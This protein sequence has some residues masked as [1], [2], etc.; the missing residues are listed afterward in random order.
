MP[1]LDTAKVDAFLKEKYGAST[2]KAGIDTAK[3]DAFIK[4]K[5]AAPDKEVVQQLKTSNSLRNMALGMQ[6]DNLHDQIG[7]IV[8]SNP[9]HAY[10][11][12]TTD[13]ASEAMDVEEAVERY[14]YNP[15]KEAETEMP[16]SVVVADNVEMRGDILRNKIKA[17]YGAT[18]ASEGYGVRAGKAATSLVEQLP[19]AEDGRYIIDGYEYTHPEA[20]SVMQ[21]VVENT[22]HPD[23]WKTDASYRDH[24]SWL[25]HGKSY[26][27]ILDEQYAS[28]SSKLDTLQSKIAGRIKKQAAGI[29][30]LSKD[31]SMALLGISEGE[32][33]NKLRKVNDLL[34][35]IKKDNFWSGLDE[36]FDRIDAATLGLSSFLSE[37]QMT[38]V[39]DK[40]YNGEPLTERDQIYYDL[41]EVEQELKDIRS[42]KG[43]SW[44]NT[45]GSSLGTSAEMVPSFFVGMGSVG[46]IFKMSSLPLK[47]GMQLVKNSAKKGAWEGIKK[48]VGATMKV[49]GRSLGNV[50]KAE[51][52]GMIA[53]PFL[54]STWSEVA[55]KRGDQYSL[56][57][58][59][60]VYKPKAMWKDIANAW[61]EQ[62]N[63][64]ASEFI[65]TRIGA[66]LGAGASTFGRMLGLDRVANKIG[67]SSQATKLLGYEKPQW[68]KVLQRNLG[69][70]GPVAEPLSEVWGDVAS[71]LMKEG[72]TGDGEFS[73]FK[74][75]DY[76]TTTLAVSTIYGGSVAM[77]TAPL[78]IYDYKHSPLQGMRKQRDGYLGMIKDKVLR[79]NLLSISSMGDLEQM[80]SALA[81]LDWGDMNK[82]DIA[83]G[84]DFIRADMAYKVMIGDAKESVRQEQYQNVVNDAY[85]VA[86]KGATGNTP[87]GYIVRVEA[88]DGSLYYVLR[89]SLDSASE[90][91]LTCLN[92]EGNVVP[93][94]PSKIK[95][96]STASLEDF[97]ADG[98][99]QLFATQVEMER[100][101]DIIRDYKALENPTAEDIAR[102]M[103]AFGA[104]QQNVGDTVTLVDG[105]TGV[106]QEFDAET[107]KYLVNVVSNDGNAVML[108]V[109]FYDIL[110]NDAQMASAQSSRFA[111]QTLD[112][113]DISLAQE[114]S[115]EEMQEAEA[116]GDLKVGD[117]IT[118][119]NGTQGRVIGFN[120]GNVVVDEN[121]ENT[122]GSMRDAYIEEYSLNDIIKDTPSTEA[123][124]EV[125][126]PQEA[127]E[128]PRPVEDIKIVPM[129][130]DGS[131]DYDAITD[132]S[133]FAE[134]YTKE[135]GSREEATNEVIAMRDALAAQIAENA[136]K[137][138]KATT[139][140]ERV[141]M[142]KAANA[143]A[144][145][146]AFYNK[147][148]EMLAPQEVAET[149]V[150]PIVEDATAVE[151][152][153]PREVGI[154][155]NEY[156]ERLLDAEKKV[157]NA[158]A[159]AL[160]LTVEFVKE[161]V[162]A[163]G[164]RAN[165]KIDGNKVIVGWRE[166][167]R[168]IS[169]LIGH[170]F[171]HRM[172][173]LA[174]ETYEMFKGSVQTYMGE[175]RWNKDLARMQAQ[176]RAQNKTISTELLEEEVIADFTGELVEKKDVFSSYI[177]ANKENKTL[178]DKIAEV[179]R[180]IRDFLR[181]KGVE[182][183][184]LE[185]VVSA[186]N[187]LITEA[188]AK[189]KEGV[190]GSTP[191]KYSMQA[192]SLLGV[193]NISLDKLRKVIKMGGLA[194]PSVAVIDV[195]KQTHDDYGEYSLVLPKNM[196]DARQGKN[197]GT[198]AG[199]AWT[200]T[201]P[202]IIKRIKDEKSYSRFH[203]DI[204]ALP[205]AMRNKVR[206]EF[207]S[208]MEG[209]S[210]DPLAYW[211]LFEKGSTPELVLV[212]S[213][214]SDD[215]TNAVSE[216]TKGS[217]S[218]YGLTPDER[219]KCVD[220]YIA[221]KFNGDRAAFEQEMQERI[222]R[223]T[224][225]LET[226]KSDRVKKWAQD[227]IDAIKEYGF[228]YDAVADFI[229]DVGYD[230]REKGTVND[231]A[232]TMA[233]REQ[234]KANNLEADY[235]AWLNSL[236]ERYGIDEYIFD[237]YTNSGN[238]RYLP[239]TLENV[240]KWM[241]KQ[242][243]QGADATFPSF[244]VFIATAIPKM[245]SLESIRK[246][247]ALLGK[248]KEEYDA[249]REKWE[250][251][252]FEL[253]KRLQPDAKGF[254]DYGYWR[255]IEAVGKS[256]P[257]EFIK[258]EY[259]IEMS[260]E[261][262]AM[263][264][265]MVNAIRTE[266][267]ARYFETKF[268][269]PLQL[270]DFTA[271][272]VPN[273]IPLDVESRLKDAGVEVIEYE[274]GDNASRAEAMQKASQ[275][276]NVRFSLQEVNTRF[277][278]ELATLTEENKDK[279]ILSL[280]TP[281][282]KLLAGGVVNKPMKLYGAKVIKKQKLHGFDLSEIKNLPL[283][284]ANPI[285]VFNNYQSDENR[286]VLT[287]L[288]T[289]D[290]NFLVSL[291]VGKG[292]DIDFNIVATVFGKGDDNIVDWFN[293]GLATY[294]DKEKALDYLHHSALNAEA[295]SNPRLIS[296]TNII[297]NFETPKIEAKNSLITP[298]MDADYLSAVERGD[299][300]TAQ[301]MV[302]EA[303]KLAMPN[304]KVVDEDGNPKVEY[305]G[306]PNNFNAF[307]KEMFG[308]S[309]DRGIWG[310]GFY[311]SDSEQYAKT[312]EKRGDKQGKTLSVFLN[313]K[314]PL[315]ISLRNGGNEGAMYFHELME[316][317]FT[318]D[319]Y[320]DV[321][322]TDELM[323]VAQERLTADIVANGYD[324]IVVEYTNHIDTEYVVFNPNQ[325]K[326]ADPV[327]YDD[328]G[329]VIPL[330]ERFNPKK[331]DIRYSLS[332]APTFYSNAEYAVRTIKQEK[333][334]PEQWLKMIEKNGGL[335]AGEDKW[336]GLSDWLKASDKKTL[337]KD[338]VL[339]YIAE[340]DIQIEEVSYGDVA[341]I[342]KEEI[343]ESAEFAGLREDL[344]E[345]D[346]DDNP[347]INRERYDELRSESYDFVDGFSLDYWGE[348][349]EVNSPAAAATYLGLTKADREINSTRLD[350]TTKGLAN[351]REIALVVPTIEPYNQSDEIHFGDAG[352]GR[353][354]AWIRFG[355]TEAPKNVPMHQRVDA[356]DAPF[357][358]VAGYDVY[359]PEGRGGKFSKDYVIYGKLKDGSEA[360]IAYIDTKPISKH[361]TLEEARNAMNEY[362]EANPRMVTR[363]ERVLVIDEIQSKRHQDGREKGY[364]DKRVS[365]QELYDAQEEAFSKVI[366]YE[367]A[368]ADKYGEDEWAS[369]ATA[370]EMA[371]Y[372]RLRAIDEAATNAYENYDKGVPSAPFE[373][374]WAELA[375]KR[376][377]RYAAENGYDYVAW[378]TGDQQAERYN[379]GNVI[380]RVVSYPVDDNMEI[381]IHRRANERIHLV[382]DNNGVILNSN[383]SLADAGTN[384]SEVLGKDL[385]QRIYGRE[386]EDA[387]I[388]AGRGKEYAAKEIAVD[389]LRIGGEGMKAFY[390]Q[391]LPSFV[392][393]Y[394][395]KWGAEVKDITMP[396]LEENNTMH[397]VNVTDSMRESVMQ[398]Q[399]KF[400]LRTG[401]YGRVD[402][403]TD[404][405]YEYGITQPIFVA[406]TTEEYVKMFKDMG[407]KNPEK[408]RTTNGAYKK[409]NDTIYLDAEK[410][411]RRSE[412][413]RTLLHERTHAITSRLNNQLANL[414]S[415]INKDD[416]LA[417][418]DELLSDVYK[419]IAPDSVID[420]IIS[421]IA[422]K[423][424]R[425][426]ARR[427]F[428][429]ELSIEDIITNIAPIIEN[430]GDKR[431]DDIHH[432]ILPLL[433]E[434][435][436]IQKEL[437]NGQKENPIVIPRESVGG[438]EKRDAQSTDDNDIS[439]DGGQNHSHRGAYRGAKGEVTPRFA[440][441]DGGITLGDNK[442]IESIDVGDE[443]VG[444]T[445]EEQVRTYLKHKH[446]TEVDNI[447]KKYKRLRDI[448]RTDYKERMKVR[449]DR[450]GT[451]RTNAAKIEY[452][453]G[454]NE[455][456]ALPLEHQALVRIARGEIRI[457]WENSADG[458]KRGLAA[459]VGLKDGEKRLYASLT[460]DATLYFDEAVHQWWQM[461]GGYEREVDTQD[462]RNALIE[463]LSEAHSPSM[464]ITLLR[465]IYNAEEVV[466]D[467]TMA[468]YEHEEAKEIA[469]EQSRYDEDIA[470]FETN[471]DAMIRE[472]EERASFFDAISAMEGTILDLRK[473]I[474]QIK[475]KA[476]R[477]VSNIQAQYREMR[478]LIARTK[479]AVKEVIT[480]DNIR[481]FQSSELRRLIN[482]VDKARSIY[483]VDNILV[484]VQSIMLDVSIRTQRMDMDR[485]LKLRL[486]N[487]EAVE[488]WVDQQMAEGKLSAKEG[489]DI[490][491]NMWKGK[492]ASGVSVAN[493]IDP[494]TT[495][496]LEYL[497][498][499]ISP[500]AH[501]KMVEDEEAAERG[502]MVRK[503][504]E[505]SLSQSNIEQNEARLQ[506]LEEKKATATAEGTEAYTE[507]DA[508]E[509]A[510]R[511]IYDSYLRAVMHKQDIQTILEAIQD[512]REMYYGNP[513]KEAVRDHHL[514]SL[515]DEMVEVKKKYLE[516]LQTLN[517]EMLSL[518]REGRDALRTFRM[519]EQAHK[520]A[521]LKLGLD[522][523]GVNTRIVENATRTMPRVTAFLRSTL[524][525][526]YYTFQTTLKEIDHLAPNG[527][528]EF[529]NHFMFGMQQCSDNFYIQHTAHIAEVAQK[530]RVLLGKKRKKDATLIADV[531]EESDSKII[532]T[533]T[534]G[535][536]VNRG[537][538]I[539][540]ESYDLTISNAM[541]L[542]AMW[543]QPMYRNSMMA[544]GITQEAID[545]VYDAVGKEN[546]GYIPFMN[547]VNDIFLPDT[548]LLYDK[549]HKAMFGV[550]MAKERNY[551][552][553]RVIGYEEKHDI[554]L[555]EVGML[556]STITGAIV[557]R[558]R[559]MRMPDFRM[560]YFKI[561][562]GH[563]QDLDQWSSYAPMIRD[564]NTLC[565]NTLFR[566]KCNK[567]MPGVNADG[568]GQGSLFQY[569]KTTAAIAVNCYRPKKAI[570]DDV[571]MTVLRGWAGSNI[572]F[573]GWTAI[574]QL[575]SSPVFA[576]YMLDGKCQEL[577]LRNM[578]YGLTHMRKLHEWAL[579]NSP[580]YKQRWESKFAGMDVFTKKVGEENGFGVHHKWR[581]TKAGKYAITFDNAM[582][583]FAVDLGLTP[584]AAVDAFT[585]MT[586]IKTIYDY[587][588]QKEMERDGVNTP[589]EGMKKLAMLKAEI[590]FNSTQQSGENVY[591]SQLQK[592]RTFA[593]SVLTVYLNSS[594]GFHRLRVTGAQEL[595]KQMTDAEYKKS[596]YEKYGDKA[597]EVLKD[598][599]K[600]ATSQILQGVVG[601]LL[602]AVMSGGGTI[603]TFSMFGDGDDEGET[604][605][606][607]MKALGVGVVNILTGGYMGGS[608]LASALQGYKV[609][610]STPFDELVNDIRW[611]ASND[612]L[613]AAFGHT[614]NIIS[615]Y[616]YGLDF[617][618]LANTVAGVQ[619]LIEG[620]GGNEAVMN[621]LNVPQSQ[622]AIIA[623]RRRPEE[624]SSEYV[625]RIMHME[626]IIQAE[627]GSKRER[628]L[629]K[630]YE[631]A[632]RKNVVVRTS[633]ASVWREMVTL[634]DDYK[635]ITKELGWTANAN[636]NEKVWETGMYVA[637][638]EGISEAEYLAL[639][640]LEAEIAALEGY[641]THFEG[642]EDNYYN[643]VQRVTGVK[644]QFIEQ[645]EQFK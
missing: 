445:T 499:L 46:N 480:S 435:L 153:T 361:E 557:Q 540:P 603:G 244:G 568:G 179:F 535:K 206:L 324:G 155:E 569:F 352:E 572:A 185:D 632:Y 248:S 47:A 430:T 191:E 610:M 550:S 571:I 312:Y 68:L 302:M 453:L 443:G 201:Y 196:V 140:N 586:G 528:G 219:A 59:K 200:P 239:H 634:E 100:Q 401:F 463:A 301:K 21:Q 385:S 541:Y 1:K 90:G 359:A 234:I 79:N 368:L 186:L 105:G 594:F 251:V 199:D 367:S 580:S 228:D 65:G 326:S 230:A 172:R 229:R 31:P 454:E 113:M 317:H 355:E 18:D 631:M 32:G 232:T 562:M 446:Y 26:K 574:K 625:T 187:N 36:G 482:K 279:V 477:R 536:G 490:L 56:E 120:E 644:K 336:L 641:I 426:Y 488:A 252:Y 136:K 362:Y 460:K 542:I 501:T 391:M 255:L 318:D 507:E 127:M 621:I 309:T 325:I 484:E 579:E 197:A 365:Q 423:I 416:I 139:P 131:V 72:L 205:E 348:E 123:T 221:A 44:W 218:M 242:G 74:S 389:G 240:S 83:Y 547:W 602:F 70:T 402:Y 184:K 296:A 456:L 290:G 52:M 223:L 582:R 524:N 403:I 17:E 612:S 538:I 383:S 409:T 607:T 438:D 51:A 87:T 532:G 146:V 581:A 623:G 310:N 533:I 343:Y 268:E 584:N 592:E 516:A 117:I 311:F 304:T 511:T 372:E 465:N 141:K 593:T 498:T 556:P 371:E 38:K 19:K 149:P 145:R 518:M 422:G 98:Y 522:A 635:D 176:Y 461:I 624:T 381:W 358:N 428:S 549:V 493:R 75:R 376:M 258:K 529:Y 300:E 178:L 183:R 254:D 464:A 609:S 50:A 154:I 576:L 459:E 89:G 170:E 134:L 605:E 298:E 69:Y 450:I 129:Q 384:V 470:E 327:T 525:A 433:K 277:N 48:G 478:E 407:V 330:S 334:T 452:I 577:Y 119:P 76:W 202:Q 292:E 379:I 270:S 147:V 94:H 354:V 53:A 394:T 264:N 58:G 55:S 132:A 231:S 420:E 627:D 615:K 526:P 406:E 313:I 109:P 164:T 156:S 335:K 468:L 323:S 505:L 192:P 467:E 307:S 86:Y 534:Y 333:A 188:T 551:F 28:L 144:E 410:L 502:T 6:A 293:R 92:E 245:T 3:V 161:V 377:L 360:Y 99:T 585:V 558:V 286:S 553:A 207:D 388:Y 408:F 157:Y 390:D 397:A 7:S 517:G 43:Q 521:I 287:E 130:E 350:Y 148:L 283:A 437:Y 266:Y 583:K 10:N 151:V 329:N 399:P 256:N 209:R 281:S 67:I 543:R 448:A 128:A 160:G 216:A 339:Q 171:L 386:G 291:N 125:V 250:N 338:E 173:D 545:A 421:Y 114:E 235:E 71:N 174:P 616:R 412:I 400:S 578:G 103:S 513:A 294:I 77:A 126:A 115:V 282:E 233:A 514:E 424:T 40:V 49:A 567:V 181:S 41:W 564:L 34:T 626:S 142:R 163:D 30:V 78:A 97:M 404:I 212:P 257:R 273:D 515:Q 190:E 96:Q 500:T 208:F 104:T 107:G 373:K 375:F 25:N 73:Q 93:L 413:F 121:V 527:E 353:A 466:Y 642:T 12:L 280:G 472:Y 591:L 617:E 226:K 455:E 331:E 544:H 289:K 509:Y 425:D 504:G 112:D 595:W 249:F 462:L 392:K 485:M 590:A 222:N 489:R 204:E 118:T 344:T 305:H 597:K 530:M 370:E 210:A 345:Y 606:Q 122:T 64:L 101:Q 84:M 619:G 285:A 4:E 600:K 419:N 364:S 563:L 61:I 193:H 613:L 276:E 347:Y 299:M 272:V 369:L 241:K 275:M 611:Y 643:L 599:R 471:K 214:Y 570:A 520:E 440:L 37:V 45:V 137:T 175:E 587:E 637:P 340:N 133:Q 449:M 555:N 278:E 271:A 589:T 618:T 356:F 11:H 263:F 265:D 483:E 269:R 614:M 398:G 322:R 319:I 439:R 308:T 628:E 418:R 411:S 554:S 503:D 85:T 116:V 620:S 213:R 638:A 23:L 224:E 150:E 531:I 267:P 236:E 630:Q 476:S 27:G 238:R 479:A 486:P 13:A 182:D 152:D 166:R 444:S 82:V 565:S 495:N 337:T 316:K 510:A 306:T 81:H 162:E 284:V 395:K 15:M 95:A 351:K 274:K 203:T 88:E 636:P 447:R 22:M 217:F 143:L 357:K 346:E 189:T 227:T 169:F 260:E 374:N 474:D 314:R 341:D 432:A 215:I 552:P 57:N 414:V 382:A 417:Y 560:N 396:D 451:L 497:R 492:N 66:I 220:A 321:T 427:L 262:M 429:G 548:R 604:W 29:G 8:R 91:L 60:L 608:I 5:Y 102:I 481:S 436:L 106:V 512:V 366:D 135:I 14:S 506:E 387:T 332:N 243:R 469:E 633:G 457:K 380:E 328:N 124:T 315:F 320:E 573:R 138:Q 288:T 441:R 225:A 297:Q 198:W 539:N 519:A 177:E 20:V 491:D 561:L 39:L 622:I 342:S 588:L 537:E 158:M 405:A 194:N 211:Y 261:D 54:P 80:S 237:G 167:D 645:Y 566:E 415:K 24:Y 246:R 168:A 253:G 180:A 35:S 2:N 108:D 601:D 596:I 494:T 640:Q 639:A 487:G 42:V 475:E 434:N 559:N 629:Q 473:R 508:E 546:K 159:E 63:E 303:A 458:R 247:K 575:T 16:E 33:M 363:Y 259:G 9:M 62:G 442:D 295:L 431:F 165:A 393:K 523:L 598:A 111:E 378:T 110:S 349:L 195:D 496:T